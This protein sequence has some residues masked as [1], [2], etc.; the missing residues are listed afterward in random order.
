[1]AGM[2]DGPEYGIE[3][4]VLL[5]DIESVPFMEN[6]QKRFENSNYI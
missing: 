1:M 3:D 6:L 4:F 5:K 2:H